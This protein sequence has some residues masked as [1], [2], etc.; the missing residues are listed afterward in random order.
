MTSPEMNLLG[1]NDI[2]KTGSYYWL[3][4]PY[5]FRGYYAYVNNVYSFGAFNNNYVSNGLVDNAYG[6][7]PSVSLTT[8]TEYSSGDGSMSNPY[9]VDTSEKFVYNALV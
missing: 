7:R 2:R 6:V 9:I 4:S 5:C 1:G 3:L 8:G